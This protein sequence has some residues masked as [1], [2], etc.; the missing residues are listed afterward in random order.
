MSRAARMGVICV[1]VCQVV[2][3]IIAGWKNRLVLNPDG[4]AYIAIASHYAQGE[5]NLAVS[6]YWGPLL[7]WSMVPL[8]TIFHNPM[9]AAR[10][11]LGLSAVVFLL[12]SLSVY[13]SLQIHPVG[14][15]FGTLVVAIASIFWSVENVT[16]DLLM[17]GLI[18]LAV[19]EMM[20]PGWI[21][22]IGIQLIT[23]VLFG[24]AYLAKAV[25]LPLGFS[26]C[27][28]FVLLWVVSGRHSVRPALRGL[29]VTLL[30]V[31]F[32]AAPWIAVLSVKYDRLTI[33][34]SGKVAHAI[35]GPKDVE[36]DHL[37][38]RIFHTPETG[39]IS[40]WEDPT[41]LPYKYW[42]PFESTK[43]FKHQLRLLFDNAGTV[44]E[45]LASFD[46]L[47]LALFAL[48]CGLLVHTPWRENIALERWRWAA[49]PIFCISLVYLPVYAGSH[50]YYFLA[51]PFLF[52]GSIG[53]VVWLT[54]TAQGKI[55][56]PRTLGIGLITLSFLGAAYSSFLRTLT[57]IDTDSEHTYDL[58]RKLQV[59]GIY[60]GIAGAGDCFRWGGVYAEYVAF[61]MKQ[62]FHGC[63]ANPTVER[64]KASGA[65][66]MFVNRL[67]R[68]TG[69]LDKDSSFSSLDRFLFKSKEE[70]ANFPSKIYQMRVAGEYQQTF[71]K[72]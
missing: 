17:S 11:S 15:V 61:F 32:V 21:Q 37:H 10:I 18:C 4:V 67:L 41:S 34:T 6:G 69:E 62:P 54:R 36:R 25:A 19:S 14:I 56:I 2:L 53:M 31:V 16:P 42:S 1:I 39:R 5:F 24:V 47:H 55:N 66:L 70:A 43:Y 48:L 27:M 28:G 63:E 33:S 51:Y 38:F 60:G 44:V 52:A 9:D 71:G 23:G 3:L 26:M 22:S 20:S 59:L 57:G 58:A 40:S 46:R 45:A 8:L 30:G 35:S 64:I 29:A 49:V 68:L 50:R 12:G 72:P 13:Q 65:K 7:S